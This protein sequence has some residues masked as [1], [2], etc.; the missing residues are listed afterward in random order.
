LDSETDGTIIITDGEDAIMVIMITDMVIIT[1]VTT[2]VILQTDTHQE[3]I[4]LMKDQI[5]IQN[6][7]PVIFQEGMSQQLFIHEMKLHVIIRQIIQTEALIRVET[8]EIQ[9]RVLTG[10]REVMIQGILKAE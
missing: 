6:P 9:T 1:I 2:T 5:A 4:L 10:A 7:L 8:G 3:L